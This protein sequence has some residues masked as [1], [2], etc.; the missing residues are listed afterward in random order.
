M[1]VVKGL[2][3]TGLYWWIMA[4]LEGGRLVPGGEGL[5]RRPVELGWTEDLKGA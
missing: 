5:E 3:G 4:V 2:G 1:L